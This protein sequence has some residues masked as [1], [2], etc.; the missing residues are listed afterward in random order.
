LFDRLLASIDS[1]D[2]SIENA[3]GIWVES[4]EGKKFFPIFESEDK[5]WM[6]RE[7]AGELRTMID[8]RKVAPEPGEAPGEVLERVKGEIKDLRAD[9]EK[10]EGLSERQIKRK[11]HE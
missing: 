11:L 6:E 10:K 5:N 2:Y 3:S 4:V 8:Q 7:L 9:L 1:S